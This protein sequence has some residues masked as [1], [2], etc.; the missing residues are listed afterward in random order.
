MQ[1]ASCAS[2]FRI[3]CRRATRASEIRG[4]ASDCE[5]PCNSLR[6]MYP[7]NKVLESWRRIEVVHAYATPA[8]DASATETTDN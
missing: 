4:Y 7:R 2:H 5:V 6:R 1:L 8:G 3:R